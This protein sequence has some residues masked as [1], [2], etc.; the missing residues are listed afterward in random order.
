MS[1]LL[2]L[3]EALAASIIAAMPAYFNADNVIIKRQTD[4]WNDLATAIAGSK[5]GISLH[6]GV[7]EGAAI[8][9]GGLEMELTIPLTLVCPFQPAP[10]SEPE[11]DVWQALVSHVHDLRLPAGD[12]Y[13]NRFRFRSFTDIDLD[14]DRGS[15]W[16]GRQTV[17]V[18]KHSI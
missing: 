3:R 10:G 11:E 6:I 2:D 5:H 12:S 17:F 18:K 4:V 14:N 16:L 7:A 13:N 9:D 15:P 1:R 8:E